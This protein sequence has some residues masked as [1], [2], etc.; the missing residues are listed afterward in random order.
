MEDLTYPALGQTGGVRNVL[1]PRPLAASPKDRAAKPRAGDMNA[2]GILSDAGETTRSGHGRGNGADATY[3]GQPRNRSTRHTMARVL[4]ARRLGQATR[5]WRSLASHA[6]TPGGIRGCLSWCV[7]SALFSP[8]YH[9][10]PGLSS[11][12]NLRG[13]P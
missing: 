10:Q 3:C 13:L 8:L 2:F 4:D 5:R 6:G 1:D 7:P 9:R 12:L 11:R